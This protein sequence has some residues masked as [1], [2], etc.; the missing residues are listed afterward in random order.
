MR[1][2]WLRLG[3]DKVFCLFWTE[4]PDLVMKIPPTLKGK[5]RRYN[6]PRTAGCYWHIQCQGIL[7]F[8]RVSV[9][10]NSDSAWC[11]SQKLKVVL[12]C[13][14]GNLHEV[15][16]KKLDPV[17]YVYNRLSLLVPNE[18][19][20][21]DW[22][23]LLYNLNKVIQGVNL[24]NPKSPLH[25]TKTPVWRKLGVA[26]QHE[27]QLDGLVQSLHHS[28]HE[29]L[30]VKKILLRDKGIIHNWLVSWY[31]FY[32]AQHSCRHEGG[33][34]LHPGHGEQKSGGAVKLQCWH[35]SQHLQLH[36]WGS[37]AV[38]ELPHSILQILHTSLV[39][40]SIL[41]LAAVDLMDNAPAVQNQMSSVLWWHVWMVV[42]SSRL[43][44]EWRCCL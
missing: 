16:P 42:C 3:T 44:V 37:S 13:D 19:N 35:L 15:W 6:D 38:L 31:Y 9:L 18:L 23:G 11:C 22:R 4:F 8:Y 26:N 5:T 36:R 28:P 17:K 43:V 1:T 21:I 24:W 34:S 2:R 32:S 30:K 27:W 39:L 40:G 25:Q 20:F 29:I 14:L 41:V 12:P 10:L 7:L 33:H